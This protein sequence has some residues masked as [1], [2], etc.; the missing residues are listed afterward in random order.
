VTELTAA[1]NATNQTQVQILE[2]RALRAE[3]QL[4]DDLRRLGRPVDLKERRELLVTAANGLYQYATAQIAVLRAANR[5]VEISRVEA[6]EKAIADL[7]ARLKNATLESDLSRLE[8]ELSNAEIR[9]AEELRL[10][11]Q[12]VITRDEY[13][14]L[15]RAAE[16]L[17]VKVIVAIRNLEAQGDSLLAEG[18]RV[19]EQHL[20]R[21]DVLIRTAVFPE[22]IASLEARLKEETE[23][24]TAALAQIGIK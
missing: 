9:L 21:L 20:I 5:T 22:E 2:G 1:A 7:V 18:L 12:P 10:A 11:G 8:D 4:V 14:R 16:E 23:H 13:D 6:Q 3:F 24:I 15:L 19:E 17:I